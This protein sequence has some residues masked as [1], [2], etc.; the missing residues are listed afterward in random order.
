MK[1]SVLSKLSN[2]SV[3]EAECHTSHKLFQLPCC[4]CR[5]CSE[6]TRALLFPGIWYFI[7]VRICEFFLKNFLNNFFMLVASFSGLYCSITHLHVY[8]CQSTSLMNTQQL[9]ISS[10]RIQTTDL[11]VNVYLN[12]THANDLSHPGWF[13]PW[14]LFSY[15]GLKVS[16][17]YGT[18]L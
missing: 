12:L 16:Q 10:S 7:F 5:C 8:Q 18:L 3:F 14:Y 11:S 17:L 2:E 9:C 13:C 15:F 4:C 6:V 1:L